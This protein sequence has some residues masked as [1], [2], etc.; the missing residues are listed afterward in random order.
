VLRHDAT[1]AAIT[2]SSFLATQIARV[3]E[4]ERMPKNPYKVRMF[5]SPIGHI[6]SAESSRIRSASDDTVEAPVF[7]P[8]RDERIV[9]RGVD[10]ALACRDMLT[11]APPTASRFARLATRLG[12]PARWLADRRPNSAQRPIPPAPAG[13]RGR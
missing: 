5:S 2:S 9:Q 4:R 6:L 7:E 10:E 8:T 1:W 12:A 13:A 3:E 11:A